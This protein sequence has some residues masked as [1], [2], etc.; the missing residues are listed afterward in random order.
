MHH[1][2]D[3]RTDL[4]VAPVWRTVSVAADS[5][6]DANIASTVAIIRGHAAQGLLADLAVAARLVDSTGAVHT[7]GGWPE[8]A[9]A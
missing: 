5:A 2:L 3:P 6:L 8:E 4:P 7:L 1:I 9:A